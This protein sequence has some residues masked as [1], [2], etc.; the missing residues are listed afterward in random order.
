VAG[1]VASRPR[2]QWRR[3]AA[4]TAAA[5]VASIVWL[6]PAAAGDGERPTTAVQ[7]VTRPAPSAADGGAAAVAA[8]AAGVVG[9][10]TGGSTVVTAVAA[11]AGYT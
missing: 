5:A 1:D 8:A 4:V 7:P 2:P 10:A 9:A 6:W 3:S 11:A